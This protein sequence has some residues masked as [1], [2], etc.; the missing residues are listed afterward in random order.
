MAES[1]EL[2]A[3]RLL[4]RARRLKGEPREAFLYMLDS[5]SVG[6][7]RA[8]Q[9]LR[10]RGLKD[11]NGAL[12]QLVEEGLLERERDCYNLAAPL[13]LLVARRGAEMVKKVLS[14][15]GGP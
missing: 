5:I 10:R 12:E 11:P 4:D 3:S 15:H 13:R 1:W 9:E 2:E 8:A 14:G 7:L 6:D